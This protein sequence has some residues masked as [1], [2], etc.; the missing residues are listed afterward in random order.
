MSGYIPERADECVICQRSTEPLDDD[1]W[2]RGCVDAERAVGEG[3]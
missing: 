2:C 3:S 1:G